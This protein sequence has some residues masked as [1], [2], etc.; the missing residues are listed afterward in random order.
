MTSAFGL[1]WMGEPSPVPLSDLFLGRRRCAR[2]A[3]AAVMVMMW[4]GPAAVGTAGGGRGG[5]RLRHLQEE[6]L[7]QAGFEVRRL[8]CRTF[9]DHHVAKQKE[10]L[11]IISYF[12]V[13][14]EVS[15]CISFLHVL[16]PGGGSYGHF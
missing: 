1:C 6:L 8:R 2:A 14:L 11:R 13:R 10:S 15:G 9:G 16:L 4:V 12:T 3:R 7:Q 5:V